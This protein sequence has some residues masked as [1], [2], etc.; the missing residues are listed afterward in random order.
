MTSSVDP[1]AM[2]HA[3]ARP[4]ASQVRWLWIA[5]AVC[6][7][8]LAVVTF[9][10]PR[11]LFSGDE[12]IKLVQA[13][14]VLDHGLSDPDLPYPGRAFDPAERNYPFSAPFVVEHDGHHHGIYPITFVAPSAAGWA[15]FG[16]WGL[17]LVP[18]ACGI[19]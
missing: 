10:A 14:G 6:G 2:L 16:F 13:L 17:H 1:Q 9:T 11:G 18:L 7:L 5:T 4:H 12:G 15:A 19:W 8:A 3:A